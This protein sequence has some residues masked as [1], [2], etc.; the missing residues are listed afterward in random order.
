MRTHTHEDFSRK[1]A[2]KRASERSFGFTMSAA[3]LVISLLPLLRESQPRYWA[4]GL[5][6]G[7]LLA[8]LFLPRVLRPLN[9]MWLAFGLLLARIMNPIISGLLYYLAVTPTA[10]LVRSAGHDGLR[11]RR[12][13]KADTYWI[14]R[15]PPGPD[16]H[17]MSNQF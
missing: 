3:F 1:Q 9:R 16:P 10:L 11:L 2:E 5:S 15:K 6:C 17:S 13:P 12:D 14:P 7:F 8:A 4:L